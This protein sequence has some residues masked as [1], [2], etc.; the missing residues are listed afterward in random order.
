M[1]TY[2][3]VNS[4]G[5]TRNQAAATLGGAGNANA[6]PCLNASGQ[7][8]TTMLPTGV[9]A[10]VCTGTAGSALSANQM[11]ALINNSGVLSVV[12]AD[13]TNSRPAWGYVVAA[14]ASAATATVYKYGTVGGQS[15]LTVGGNVYLS[16]AGT[17]TQTA[18]S[19]VGTFSQLV[20]VASSTTA[21]EFAP[22]QP[23]YL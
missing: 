1:S 6:I 12:P 13:N 4:A 3:A 18:P 15:S 21:F 11:V 10:D 16:T 19:T 5:A 22:Q 14:F 17:I 8:D 23:L 9:G 20:G 7:L 2:Y